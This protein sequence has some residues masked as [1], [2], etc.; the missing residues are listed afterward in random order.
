[1]RQSQDE[2]WSWETRAKTRHECVE[3]E[4]RQRRVNM[5]HSGDVSRDSIT[6]VGSEKILTV[7]TNWRP[8]N[9]S[10]HWNFKYWL[11]C[12]WRTGIFLTVH[13]LRS[14]HTVYTLLLD[15]C[16]LNWRHCLTAA[17]WNSFSSFCAVYPLSRRNLSLCFKSKL[18]LLYWTACL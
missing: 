10:I 17:C 9:F 12:L 14:M 15:A 8:T 2:T 1:M 16:Q 11:M 6:V 4:S 7:A 13:I 3:T 18:D 5:C